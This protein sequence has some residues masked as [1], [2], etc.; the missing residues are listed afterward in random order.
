MTQLFKA[1]GSG[2]SIF[3]GIFKD[4]M[5]RIMYTMMAPNSNTIDFAVKRNI[6]VLHLFN[7]LVPDVH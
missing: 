2:G 4:Q 3:Q 1:F 7:P 6:C 5:A